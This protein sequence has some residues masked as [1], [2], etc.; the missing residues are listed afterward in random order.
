VLGGAGARRRQ[1]V[2]RDKRSQSDQLKAGCFKRR[3]A[4]PPRL[5]NVARTAAEQLAPEGVLTA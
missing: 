3:I 2:G 1:R 4:K 5:H